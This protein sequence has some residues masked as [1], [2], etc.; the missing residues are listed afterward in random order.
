MFRGHGDRW[1]GEPDGTVNQG[2]EVVNM[3]YIIFVSEE[4]EEAFEIEPPV[5]SAADGSVV[6]VKTVDVDVCADR[7]RIRAY[8]K[9]GSHIDCPTGLRPGSCTLS[10]A[11]RG[12]LARCERKCCEGSQLRSCELPQVCQMTRTKL[13]MGRGYHSTEA[14]NQIVQPVRTSPDAAPGDGAQHKTDIGTFHSAK[15]AEKRPENPLHP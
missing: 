10:I 1:F 12:D 13:G 14:S 6:E 7:H 2:G 5:G 15:D 11:H 4:L 3:S 8:K 9:T